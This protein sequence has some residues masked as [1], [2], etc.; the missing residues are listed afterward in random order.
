MNFS[1]G[2][3]TSPGE[4]KLHCTVDYVDLRRRCLTRDHI[5]RL[6]PVLVV[7]I[8]HFLSTNFGKCIPAR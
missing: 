2:W 5:H 3:H 8:R 4:K 1:S 7:M 6:Q